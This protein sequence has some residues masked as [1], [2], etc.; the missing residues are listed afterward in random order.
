M[1]EYI[2]PVDT[3]GPEWQ[4]V[5]QPNPI[6]AFLAQLFTDPTMGALLSGGFNVA[7]GVGKQAINH[8]KGQLGEWDEYV[9]ASGLPASELP[10]MS[11]ETLNRGVMPWASKVGGQ[12]AN[13]T[14]ITGILKHF[15]SWNEA[16]LVSKIQALYDMRKSLGMNLGARPGEIKVPG[17][18]PYTISK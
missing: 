4:P 16:N 2:A 9:K 6:M 15:G 17:T 10:T 8:M 5:D 7:G 11:P 3:S 18:K 13:N 12:G 1:P 14:D